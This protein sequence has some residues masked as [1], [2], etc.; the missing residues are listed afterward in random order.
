[1]VLLPPLPPQ[2]GPTSAL[3]VSEASAPKA[4]SPWLLPHTSWNP[5]TLFPRLLLLPLKSFLR[6][7]CLRSYPSFQAQLSWSFCCLLHPPCYKT[8]STFHLFPHLW[9]GYLSPQPHV[10]WRLETI[11]HT[12]WC[13][14]YGAQQVFGA[15]NCFLDVR[16]KKIDR[17]WKP[18]AEIPFQTV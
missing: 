15:E 8:Y 6:W 12:C 9:G 16:G 4:W 1:M 11:S 13:W 14:P 3:S 18:N 10:C 7:S 2:S 17:K 5:G